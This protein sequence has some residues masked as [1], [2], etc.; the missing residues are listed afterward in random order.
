MSDDL[1]EVVRR[2]E[3]ELP[4]LV[5]AHVARVRD[6]IDIYRDDGLV[7]PEDLRR[8]VEANMRFMIAALRDPKG[9]NDFSA[10]R[11]TGAR[12]ARQGAP[13][14]EVLRAYRLGFTAL[15]DTLAASADYQRPAL[16]RALLAAGR[17]L[18]LLTDEYAIQLTE[19]YRATMAEL[20][21]ARERRRSAL[22]E[23]LFTG[24]PVA[25]TTHWEITSLLGFPPDAGLV[26]VMAETRRAD[27][28]LPG[29][30]QRLAE[31]G[32][33]SV[34]RLTPA[35]Q[36]GIVALPDSDPEPLVAL[37]RQIAKARI[38]MSQPYRAIGET[39]RA[40]RLARIALVSAPEGSKQVSAFRA[41]RVAGLVAHAPAEGVRVAQAV[42]GPILELPAED[43]ET[44]LA[45]IRAWFDNDGSA[46]RTGKQL[47]CHRNTV[48]YRLRRVQELTGHSFANPADIAELAVALEAVPQDR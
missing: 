35:L 17:G 12:R 9:G 45:T 1:R 34:W 46:E 37:L 19:A 16:M 30:E 18:W 5:D 47:H 38:G 39:P 32:M 24:E 48:R 40:V 28:P 21:L 26:V 23:A 22:A 43:R 2:A 20:T 3:A 41:G 8:S 42:L 31:H 33:V 10:P 7:Q 6:E 4:R 13:L 27:E 36:T 15:W 14:P 44:L 29:I 25:G 11:E